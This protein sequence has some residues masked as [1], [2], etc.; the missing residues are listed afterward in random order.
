MGGRHVYEEFIHII[1]LAEEAVE[2]HS[3]E[4]TL[5]ALAVD[6]TRST[7]ECGK[8]VWEVLQIH[9]RATRQKMNV[10]AFP[11]SSLHIRSMIHIC[12]H[13]VAFRRRKW[14]ILKAPFGF[15]RILAQALEDLPPM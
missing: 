14:T 5:F 9:W 7:I 6:E 1:F 4:K 2:F 10:N 3:V 13:I 11:C 8:L 12:Q 15:L